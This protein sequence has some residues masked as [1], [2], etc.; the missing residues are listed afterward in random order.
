MSLT[1]SQVM[2]LLVEGRKARKAGVTEDAYPR[3]SSEFHW[4]SAG[5]LDEDQKDVHMDFLQ[6]EHIKIIKN[7]IQSLTKELPT[8]EYVEFLDE[9]WKWAKNRADRDRPNK[10]P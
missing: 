8:P 7:L 5:W 4:W 1:L 6:D 3:G 9:I 2:R 10:T